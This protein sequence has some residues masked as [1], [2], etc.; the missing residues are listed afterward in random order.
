MD[1]SMKLI[2][3]ILVLLVL[4]AS[5]GEDTSYVT[6]CYENNILTYCVKTK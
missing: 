1:V 3:I 4:I 5:C 6:R 2:G